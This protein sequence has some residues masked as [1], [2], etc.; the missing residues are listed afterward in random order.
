VPLYELCVV[1]C[2]Y[3]VQLNNVSTVVGV[4]TQGGEGGT[5]WVTEYRV[6]HSLDGATWAV[7]TIEGGLEN[8]SCVEFVQL[9]TS[10]RGNYY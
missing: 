5:D 4:V 6:L 9:Y 10:F 2:T 3:Q 7:A 1:T 8:V